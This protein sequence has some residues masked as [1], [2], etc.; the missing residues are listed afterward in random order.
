MQTN[1]PPRWHDLIRLCLWLE[2]PDPDSD[3]AI[4]ETSLVKE[5][6][7]L[8]TVPGDKEDVLLHAIRSLSRQVESFQLLQNS[9]HETVIDPKNNQG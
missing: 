7:P 1:E 9:L 6:Q 2:E 8:A 3:G 5:E 4:D